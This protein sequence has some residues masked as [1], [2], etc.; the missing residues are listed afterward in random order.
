MIWVSISRDDRGYIAFDNH[1][2]EKDEGSLW[3]SLSLKTDN[4]SGQ[5]HRKNNWIR[6][7]FV[8]VLTKSKSN[9]SG[10]RSLSC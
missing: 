9:G 5:C 6:K 3:G 2:S 10:Y 4:M 1:K 7:I 8:K